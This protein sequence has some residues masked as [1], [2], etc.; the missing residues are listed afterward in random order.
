MARGDVPVSPWIWSSAD[1]QGNK[2]TITIPYDNTSKAILNG[3]NVVR[4]VG[5]VYGHL[6][7]GLG[8][9][10]TPNTTTHVFAVSVGTRAVTAAQMSAVGLNTI[11]DV[12]AL[13]VTAGP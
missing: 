11:S 12:L 10:G 9:D 5:C 2:I 8:A 13:Q 4:D 7:I 6:Y 3:S 1:Y